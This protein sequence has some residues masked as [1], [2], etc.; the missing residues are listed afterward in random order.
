METFKI[1]ITHPLIT[2][3]W[4]K[5]MLVIKKLNIKILYSLFL[6]AGNFNFGVYEYLWIIA[7]S[8]F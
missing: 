8:L 7:K 6:D 3:L 5:N 2:K 1:Q 4:K